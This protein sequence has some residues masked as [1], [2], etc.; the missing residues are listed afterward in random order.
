ME[1]AA[2]KLDFI[3]AAAHRDEMHALQKLMRG[4]EKS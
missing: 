3:A 1:E 2:K 4:K